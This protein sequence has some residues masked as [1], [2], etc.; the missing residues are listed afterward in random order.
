[1]LK[2]FLLTAVALY[3]IVPAVFSQTRT[4]AAVLQ[5]ISSDAKERETKNFERAIRLAKEKGWPVSFKTSDQNIAFLV[6]VDRFGL[7]V[8]FSTENAI[9]AATTGANQLWTGGSSGL[10]LSGASASVR[11][12][13]AVWDGGRILGNHVELNGRVIQK[14]NPS[15]TSD[16]A[17]HVTG[18]MIASGVNASAK[19][20][21]YAFQ[22]LLAYDFNNHLNE[23]A[24]E[25][26]NLLISN[27][28]YGTLA[29]WVFNQ[30]QSRW[31]FYGRFNENEDFKMGYYDDDAQM[32]DSISYNAPYYLIVKSAGNKRNENGPA[33][34]ATYWRY[35]ATGQMENAGP[36]P[37]GIYSNDAYDILPTYATAKNILT[38]GAV[39]GLPNGYTTASAVTMSNFSSWGPT[40]DGR[41]KPDVVANGV[42]VFSSVA[43]S[44]T[45]YSV[46]GGTSMATPNTSGSLMLLQEYYSQLHGGA[47]MR[48]STLKGLA[49]HT[50]EES[51]DAPGPDYR[52]GWGLLNVAKGAD[53]IK[54][55]NTGA[56]RIFENVLNNGETFTLNIPAGGPITATLVW[57]D[58][59]GAIETTNILNNTTKKLVHD[60]DIK[61]IQGA[62]TYRPWI[63]DP[64][65]PA[66]PATTGDNTID[67]VEKVSIGSVITGATYTIQITHKGTLQRGSQAYSLIISGVGAQALCASAPT[68]TAGARIDSVGFGGIAKR[69]TGTCTSYTDFTS[70]SAQVEP[71]QTL[72]LTVR[73]NSCDAS[74]ADKIVKA[75]IDFNN[76]GSFSDAGELIA[77][78]NVISGDGTFTAN[79]SIPANIVVGNSSIMRVIVQET[80]NAADV[81]PCGNYTRGETQDYR[82][83]YSVPS[84]DLTIEEITV[85]QNGACATNL[86]YV[87]VKIRNI[88]L[89]SR[90]NIPVL[91][92]VKNG[93]STV[94]TINGNYPGTIAAGQT[95]T[96]TF[97]TAFAASP[98]ITYNLAANTDDPGD[99]TRSNDTLRKDVSYAASTAPTTGIGSICGTNAVLKVTNPNTANYYWYEN[100]FVENP[101]GRG[102]TVT[103][104]VITANNT[105]YVSTGARGR[106]GLA[107]KSA[108]PNG[109]GYLV[110]TNHYMRFN[111]EVPVTLETVR[112][113]TKAA[114]QVELIVGDITSENASGFTYTTLSSTTIDVYPTSPTPASGNQPGY[115]AADNGAVFYVNLLLPSGNH[116]IIIRTTGGASLFYNDNVTGNPYP[117]TMPGVISFTG[118][119]AFSATNPN[120]FQGFYYFLYDMRVRTAACPNDRTAVTATVAA[121][122]TI[123]Q[124][125]NTLVSSS[126]TGNQW[127]L[128]NGII[129]GATGKEYVP[130]QSGNYTVRVTND[131]GCELSSAALNIVITAI[132]PVNDP[133]VQFSLSPNPNR[134][135]FNLKFR[136]ER[137][138]DAR[139]DVLNA[140][141]QTVYSRILPKFIGNF[142][143]PVEL[144]SASAGIYVL[145]LQCGGKTYYYKLM[146]E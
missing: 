66:N 6:G 94:A 37:A 88:G 47:F 41:I 108:Y 42:N 124:T 59:K 117:F 139:I 16:H 65:N 62:N 22:D 136:S 35:N 102:V 95:R 73:V 72:P 68:S 101:L 103:T 39:T 121:T 71:N 69:N 55:K 131:A 122:P 15:G 134:G 93:A 99:Q 28:S 10:N 25:A 132:D 85:P 12:K 49:I 40:D 86:Q 125:G 127:Y 119:S 76:N 36:R 90:S 63:L 9:A 21:A 58:P 81:Q 80:S 51:G 144:N 129:A 75:F 19:G 97:Q 126:N 50:A 133:A 143:G 107:A 145:R 115:D 14:D 13:M 33:V 38:V 70:I 48:A 104:P 135:L 8:Y 60:L 3:A 89:V 96:Y 112:L 44:T 138:E 74:S 106:V 64:A 23:I 98:N 24:A 116:A 84:T 26:A 5:K 118:N 7:P 11:G 79:V 77:T 29:G 46:F 110:N 128:N 83:V 123:T 43:T 32:L 130:T 111:A 17:T 92:T 87:T 54:T 56:H 1:M 61:I 34:G 114:G 27:H 105:Y 52:F 45:S 120:N 91:L 141:G 82:V 4:N 109:G 67:N 30:A 113:Y 140:Q 100:S 18:T 53:V 142:N 57:T 78:S 137:R 146:V 31:E 20:M 2:K